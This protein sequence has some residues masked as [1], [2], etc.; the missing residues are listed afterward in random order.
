MLFRSIRFSG[1]EFLATFSQEQ[2]AFKSAQFMGNYVIQENRILSTEHRPLDE[3]V[4]LCIVRA[5]IEHQESVARRNCKTYKGQAGTP[6]GLHE[7]PAMA[8][9]SAKN[10][11]ILSVVKQAAE[12]FYGASFP[13]EL[14]GVF[15]PLSYQVEK[16]DQH[17]IAQVTGE[18][19]FK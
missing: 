14:S 17:Y 19:L 9:V 8:I 13:S 3:E 10:N 5:K 16:K 18:V 15:Y 7:N 6:V 1:M 11:A 2:F 4:M 12:E